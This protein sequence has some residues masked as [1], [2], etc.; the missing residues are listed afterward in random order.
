MDL[1]FVNVLCVQTSAQEK[2]QPSW[3][4]DL[5]DPNGAFVPGAFEQLDQLLSNPNRPTQ[6]TANSA[7]TLS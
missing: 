2:C 6:S 5:V 3:L 1:T 4:G 7:D